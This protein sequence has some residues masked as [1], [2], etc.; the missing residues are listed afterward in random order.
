MNSS[1]DCAGR[2]RRSTFEVIASEM[3][4]YAF[5][6]WFLIAACGIALVLSLA[7]I[8]AVMSFTVAHRTREIGI[9][10][11]LG[12]DRRRLVGAIFRRPLIQV[13]LGIGAGGLLMLALLAG[14]GYVTLTA[15]ALLLAYLTI[16]TGVCLLAAVVPTRRALAVE[17]SEALRS[18]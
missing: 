10:V 15:F 14:D 12:A 4:F 16:M 5:W 9:R 7:G 2:P 1:P 13:A 18:E 3:R 6:T 11:A 8:Y 17:P